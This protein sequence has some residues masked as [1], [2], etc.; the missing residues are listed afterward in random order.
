MYVVVKIILKT[1][2]KK[3]IFMHEEVNNG[4]CG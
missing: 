4:R 1:K 3:K 2:I